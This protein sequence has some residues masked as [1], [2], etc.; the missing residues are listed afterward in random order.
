MASGKNAAI[1]G[2]NAEKMSASDG[3]SQKVTNSSRKHV[4]IP[5][6]VYPERSRRTG[7]T[8]LVGGNSH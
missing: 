8:V 3:K 5:A 7:M 4:W 1:K 2:Y 6:G